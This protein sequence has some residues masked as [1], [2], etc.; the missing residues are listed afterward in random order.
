V[1]ERSAF[2]WTS[3]IFFNIFP[4]LFCWWEAKVL[5]Q[6]ICWGCL[7]GADDVILM[8]HFQL[9]WSVIIIIMRPRVF[10]IIS[11]PFC[12]ADSDS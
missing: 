9:F 4:V 7:G 12:F 5:S 2:T 10:K 3:V 1:T 8:Q 6:F 11:I